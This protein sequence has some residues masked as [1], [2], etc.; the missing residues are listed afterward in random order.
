[1]PD[2]SMNKRATLQ[3]GFLGYFG[4]EMKRES[5]PGYDWADDQPVIGSHFPDAQFLF[6]NTVL[7]Y[8][9]RSGLWK[10]F[11]LV[12]R[13]ALDPIATMI[14]SQK[15]IGLT[16]AEVDQHVH[17]VR[18]KWEAESTLTIPKASLPRF[19]SATSS[20]SY[21]N[22]IDLV[23]DAIKEGDSYEMTLTTKFKAKLKEQDPFALYCTLRAKNPAPYAAYLHFPGSDMSILSSSPERFISITRDG[24][25]EMKPIKGTVARSKDLDEDATRRHRLATDV[26]E[27]AENLMVS[28][29][30]I[31][32]PPYH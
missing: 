20:D 28:S 32:H 12:R 25:A 17:K 1:M 15:P 24:V 29:V 3:L 8:D 16:E 14:G 11:C 2:G 31:G 30:S 13:S 6:A 18:A 10:M 5:L 26:K 4:Y 22:A 21:I 27:L 23:R 19:S 7:R 9:H